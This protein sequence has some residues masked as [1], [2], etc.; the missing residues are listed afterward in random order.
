MIYRN[1]LN[2]LTLN[3]NGLKY[4]RLLRHPTN[5][6]DQARIKR[7]NKTLLLTKRC[8]RTTSKV[9][10]TAVG[11]HS[12]ISFLLPFLSV[13][14]KLLIKTKIIQNLFTVTSSVTTQRASSECILSHCLIIN[15]PFSTLYDFKQ[16]SFLHNEKAGSRKKKESKLLRESQFYMYAYKGVK[17]NR[18]TSVM[19]I[20]IIIILIQQLP[21]CGNFYLDSNVELFII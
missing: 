13:E 10:S 7:I 16:N 19:Y 5:Y 3:E 18:Y 15:L 9:N 1:N 12:V 21:V 17:G 14:V 6:C 20:I 2:T 11:D 8:R 4:T